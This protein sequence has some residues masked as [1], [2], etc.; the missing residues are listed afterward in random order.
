MM[1]LIIHVD[2]IH[3]ADGAIYPVAINTLGVAL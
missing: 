1:C 3:A 2:L